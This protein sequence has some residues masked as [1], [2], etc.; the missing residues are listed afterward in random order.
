MR[1]L[2]LG[3]I[4]PLVAAC[5]L[6]A[7]DGPDSAAGDKPVPQA[8]QDQAAFA[9]I[10]IASDHKSVTLTDG[11]AAGLVLAITDQTAITR[12][13]KPATL[14]ELKA[15]QQVRITYHGATAVSIDQLGKDKKKKKKTA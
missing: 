2:A 3:V 1:F 11:K 10:T 13:L 6:S 14:S 12:D 8:E 15:D 9:T 7:A 4:I 5:G